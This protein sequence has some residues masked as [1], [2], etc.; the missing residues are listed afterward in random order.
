MFKTTE[1]M[2]V[3]SIV[4]KP[5]SEHLVLHIDFSKLSIDNVCTRLTS[6][7]LLNRSCVG[8]IMT[9]AFPGHDGGGSGQVDCRQ[10][11]IL[12]MTKYKA[13]QMSI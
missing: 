11:P 10:G 5:N 3:H 2:Q 13:P 7:L 1:L 8:V 12:Q 9:T 6:L 4:V